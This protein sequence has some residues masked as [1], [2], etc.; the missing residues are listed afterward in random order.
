MIKVTI[1]FNDDQWEVIKEYSKYL[2]R[3]TGHNV[4]PQ[5]LL[6][7]LLDRTIKHVAES[8]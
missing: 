4:D 1:E 5:A 2:Y 8:I 3:Q 6:Q 7:H